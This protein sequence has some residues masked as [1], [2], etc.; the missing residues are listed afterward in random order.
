MSASKQPFYAPIFFPIVNIIEAY[1]L[2]WKEVVVLPMKI[3][4]ILNFPGYLTLVASSIRAAIFAYMAM[5]WVSEYPGFGTARTF[6]L[7]WM[8][9]LVTRNLIFTL[10]M[11]GVW[12]WFLY[13]SPMK[14]KMHKY[15]ITPKYPSNSQF[16]QDAKYTTLASLIAAGIEISL[17]HLWSRGLLSY[18][19]DWWSSPYLNFAVLG[20]TTIWRSPHF[21]L[22]HRLMHPWRSP[23]LPD[24]GKFLYK[25]V[26]SLHH[27]SHN[28]T[29]WSGTSMH[30]VESFLYYSA[31]FM[32]ALAGLHPLI[33]LTFIVDAGLSAR[34]SHDGFTWPGSGNPFHMLHHSA[35]DCNYGNEQIPLDILFGTFAAKKGDIRKIWH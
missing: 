8:M 7:G 28:P 27:K 34:T 9:I 10:V 32:P 1:K 4:G 29:S 14:E 21:Y 3:L 6:E 5:Y 23:H 17:C 26:H 35:F 16:W 13:F 11:C 18:H 19:T 24:I 33:T 15:K 20:T 31:C 12:D 25:H 30:P 2:S 22:I